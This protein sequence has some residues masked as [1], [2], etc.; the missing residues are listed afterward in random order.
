MNRKNQ[1]LEKV[2]MRH[3]L[4]VRLKKPLFSFMDM[5]GRMVEYVTEMLNT[6]KVK[7]EKNDSRFDVADEKLEN[8]YF[9]S[10]KN[11]GF[12]SELKTSF[13]NFSSE[14]RKLL[15]VLK[16]F[17]DYRIFDGLV[18]V[19]TKS[20]ILYHRKFDSNLSIHEAYKNILV[21]RHRELSEITGSEIVDTLYIFDLKLKNSKA[22]VLTGPVTKEEALAKFFDGE[23][24][25]EYGRRFTKD[26]G[27][28][29]SIDV[30]GDN[31]L[32]ITDFDALEKQ[33]NSQISDIETVFNGF[34]KLFSI[35][36]TQ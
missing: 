29:L 2:I 36:S 11:F 35:E 28:L 4:E 30:A 31:P 9:F 23:I 7:L 8:L 5:R 6:N 18:R 12:Q 34:K 22:N 19:G 3:I 33:V 25:Q 17:Q 14:T 1:D 21:S 15:E 20:I 10:I 13:V 27:M 26:N 24:G 32:S 16:K